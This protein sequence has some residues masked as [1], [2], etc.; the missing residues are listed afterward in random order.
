VFALTDAGRTHVAEHA[1]DL[2]EP[3]VV[4]DSG[5]VER[6]QQLMQGMAGLGAAVEQVARLADEGQT[7]R[8]VAAI[9]EARRAMYRILAGDEEPAG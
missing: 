2:R 7:A 6:V 8:A 9:D 3:W 4:A 5:P 1:D